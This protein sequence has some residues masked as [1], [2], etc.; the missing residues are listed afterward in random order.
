MLRLLWV[1]GL[2]IVLSDA[3]RYYT[4]VKKLLDP[5]VNILQVFVRRWEVPAYGI[6]RTSLP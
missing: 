3:E 2:V 1:R 4:I 5:T 6:Q